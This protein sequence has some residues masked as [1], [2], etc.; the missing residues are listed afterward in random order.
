MAAQQQQQQQLKFLKATFMQ[1]QMPDLILNLWDYSEDLQ[2]PICNKYARWCIQCISKKW[3]VDKYLDFQF[4][5]QNVINHNKNW[6]DF[7]R[8]SPVTK[9]YIYNAITKY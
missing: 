5:I 8:I 7:S 1:H 2:C 9:N 6:H 4:V 3:N